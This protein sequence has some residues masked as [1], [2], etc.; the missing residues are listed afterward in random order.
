MPPLECAIA[1]VTLAQFAVF[2]NRAQQREEAEAARCRNEVTR[3]LAPRILET[4]AYHWEERRALALRENQ[5][6]RVI[7]QLAGLAQAK[8]TRLAYYAREIGRVSQSYENL[9]KVSRRD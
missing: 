6:A 9:S 2:I 8:A 5:D 3:L 4:R 1:A 7:D